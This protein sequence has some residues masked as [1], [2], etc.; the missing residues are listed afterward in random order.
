VARHHCLRGATVILD[1]WRYP[2][3]IEQLQEIRVMARG[4]KRQRKAGLR[5]AAQSKLETVRT[6]EQPGKNTAQTQ[7]KLE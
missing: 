6:W 7:E 2:E 3:C 1:V 5:G 4:T